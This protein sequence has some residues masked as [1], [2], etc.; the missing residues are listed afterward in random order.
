MRKWEEIV[1]IIVILNTS[2]GIIK[3]VMQLCRGKEVT[4]NQRH[5]Q[6]SCYLS[7]FY[8]FNEMSFICS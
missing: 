2:R 5:Y 3:Q 4:L 6:S 8:I 1:T 7:Y